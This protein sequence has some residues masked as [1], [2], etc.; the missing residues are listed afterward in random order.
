MGFEAT[1]TCDYCINI[2]TKNPDDLF[3]LKRSADPT[4]R[5]SA[6]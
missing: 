1:L 2:I 6:I 5:L 4:M 3:G